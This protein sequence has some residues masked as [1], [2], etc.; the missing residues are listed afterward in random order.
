VHGVRINSSEIQAPAFVFVSD[1]SL[2]VPVT[3]YLND[4]NFVPLA[5][6]TGILIDSEDSAQ[7]VTN[8]Y[9]QNVRFYDPLSD[10]TGGALT[11][12][13]FFD[14][15]TGINIIGS[16]CTFVIVTDNTMGSLALENSSILVA[17][18]VATPTHIITIGDPNQIIE[19]CLVSCTAS[20]VIFFPGGA[21][22]RVFGGVYN[23]CFF[24]DGSDFCSFHGVEFQGHTHDVDSVIDG[25]GRTVV[26]GC[27][28][29]AHGDLAVLTSNFASITGNFFNDEGSDAVIKINDNVSVIADN[30]FVSNSVPA[31]LETG[32]MSTARIDNNIWTTPPTLL[33]GTDA[34]VNGVLQKNVD[35]VDTTDVFV[36]V[37]THTNVKGMAG[38]G[39]IKNTGPDTLTYRV[40]VT[41]PYGTVATQSFD[42]VSGASDFWRMDSVFT[43]A[44][45]SYVSFGISVQ[46]KVPGVPTTFSL[47]HSSEGAY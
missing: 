32:S 30:R 31:I 20:D 38:G 21:G 27:V 47:R 7:A 23:S 18:G 16:G 26:Q 4:C 5:D 41:D 1:S 35:A 24:S 11:N 43:G 44:L 46:S 25:S 6:G 42:V 13:G 36:N 45:P 29:F 28:F 15:Q 2:G 40:E 17:S 33:A 34:I 8:A 14:D 19:S 22:L 37:F 12:G 9:M 10:S 39:S 3:M